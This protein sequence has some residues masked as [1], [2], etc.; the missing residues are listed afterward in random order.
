M[1]YTRTNWQNGAAGGTPI[2]AARL[3]NIEQ[4]IVS[5]E[6]GKL[7]KPA[8]PTAT[9]MVVLKADGTTATQAI[10]T[11]GGGGG[12]STELTHQATNGSWPAVRPAATSVIAAGN[13]NFSSDPPGWLTD[14]DLY[15]DISGQG[16]SP[17][18]PAW[19]FPVANPSLLSKFEMKPDEA[20]LSR[21]ANTGAEVTFS[22]LGG[23]GYFRGGGKVWSNDWYGQAM[24][25]P[26]SNGDAVGTSTWA[27]SVTTNSQ[28]IVLNGNGGAISGVYEGFLQVVVDGQIV[29]DTP[30]ATVGEFDGHM[31]GIL[32]EFPD[33][34]TRTVDI[35]TKWSMYSIG[36]A[37]G[38]SLTPGNPAG[39]KKVAL[40]GDSWTQGTDQAG[41]WKSYAHVVQ[42][43]T[44][45]WDVS[46]NGLG[47]TGWATTGTDPWNLPFA[48]ALRQHCVAD[49][50]P[51]LIVAYGSINDQD[52]AASTVKAKVQ[53]FLSG[54]ASISPT[55]KVLIVGPEMERPNTLAAMRSITAPNLLGVVD[56]SS[57][58]TSA[59]LG[60]S[61]MV[62][63]NAQGVRTIAGK[64]I[65]TI[66]EK[67]GW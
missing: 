52:S 42:Q 21:R 49:G 63:P 11:G 41:A 37:A 50:I 48:A 10:P 64:M 32:L 54:V 51:D 6:T 34:K 14:A 20:T 43:T 46:F 19:T 25:R 61:D 18:A 57:W 28:W 26:G 1:A 35:Y 40:L 23:A 53:E 12:S 67:A 62:H 29:W 60:P 15:L 2:N 30:Q 27:I 3:N 36:R 65:A 47:G 16:T 56:P 44:P 38:S 66:K 5:H 17:S 39:K 59:D 4:G 8:N 22:S 31:S 45:G 13:P 9:Q 55:S 58:F 33:A 7:D 24:H